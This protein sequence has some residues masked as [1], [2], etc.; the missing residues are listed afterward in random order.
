MDTNPEGSSS[1]TV[2]QAAQAFYGLMGGDEEAKAQP[3]ASAEEINA[4]LGTTPYFF[5]T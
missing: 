3:E 4:D 2:G 1:K 5:P